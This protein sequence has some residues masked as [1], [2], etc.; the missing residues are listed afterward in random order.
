MSEI[1][2]RQIRELV[3]CG[4]KVVYLPAYTIDTTLTLYGHKKGYNSNNSGWTW[5]LFGFGTMYIVTGY[6]KPRVK[7]I[8]TVDGATVKA[9]RELDRNYNICSEPDC[10]QQKNA[11]IELLE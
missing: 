1:K 8:E 9:L 3:E 4:A 5:D 11:I 10:M 6:T 2:V 7:G